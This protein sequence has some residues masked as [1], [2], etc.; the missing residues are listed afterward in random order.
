[1]V[2]PYVQ[3]VEI[4]S[5]LYPT[6]PITYGFEKGR[7]G[8]TSSPLAEPIVVPHPCPH[9]ASPL[10][11]LC[12][13]AWIPARWGHT[14]PLRPHPCHV[15][16]PCLSWS[17]LHRHTPAMDPLRPRV[18][19]EVWS[20]G[21][22]SGSAGVARERGAASEGDAKEKKGKRGDERWKRES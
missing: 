2:V 1:M 3:E 16:S 22:G 8:P 19:G 12:H 9:H 18:G 20:C 4:H 6:W 11:M 13:H 14:T 5:L 15:V 21:R 7:R 10:P 17:T